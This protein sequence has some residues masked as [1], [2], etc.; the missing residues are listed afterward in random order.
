MEITRKDLKEMIA[1]MVEEAKSPAD[2]RF[3]KAFDKSFIQE[4]MTRLDSVQDQWSYD[5]SPELSGT[6][7]NRKLI[8]TLDKIYD[9][10]DPFEGQIVKIT[11]EEDGEI[12]IAG[13]WDHG[14]QLYKNGK[15]LD[16]S[17]FDKLLSKKGSSEVEAFTT[18]I[19]R[20]DEANKAFRKRS[21]RE[22]NPDER[23]EDPAKTKAVEALAK[24]KLADQ[25]AIFGQ[26][27]ADNSEQVAEKMINENMSLTRVVQD[28]IEDSDMELS[29][30]Y[31]KKNLRDK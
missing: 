8:K 21:D 9:M 26:D 25:L 14:I 22:A 17:W 7:R 24:T 11:S 29:D 4:L 19:S 2:A 23:G 27:L 30:F 6:I 3:L 18:W 16:E 5:D 12:I 31:I 15:S 28:M 1:S 10:G 13:H 20:G